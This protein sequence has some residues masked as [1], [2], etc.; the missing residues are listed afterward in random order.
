[1]SPT[2]FSSPLR[3]LVAVSTLL[4][5]LVGPAGCAAC[6]DPA[7]SDAAHSATST[8]TSTAKP[9]LASS[10]RPPASATAQAAA[11]AAPTLSAPF[12]ALG[13][14]R[15]GMSEAEA[16]AAWPALRPGPIPTWL[17]A[18]GYELRVL[19]GVV[20]TV[21]VQ[22]AEVGGLEV[23][24]KKLAPT[25][26]LAEAV[27]AFAG[28]G[29]EDVRIG[30]TVVYCEKGAVMLLAGGVSQTVYVGIGEERPQP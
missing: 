30:A 10:A 22:L 11:G 15:V 16:R 8:A 26:S 29:P 3:R 28:C 21:R 5:S 13:P 1:M 6:A 20:R 19:E 12:D 2:W 4:A 24:G 9:E 23:Q 14:F 18:D 17:V 27:V 25:A 7:P